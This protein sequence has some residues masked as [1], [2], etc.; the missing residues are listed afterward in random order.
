M[1]GKSKK[2]TKDFISVLFASVKVYLIL[3]IISKGLSFTARYERVGQD[4]PLSVPQ[5]VTFA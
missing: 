2:T 1:D 3:T 4:E 5:I